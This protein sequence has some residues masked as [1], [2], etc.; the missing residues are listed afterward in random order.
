MGQLLCA[1]CKHGRHAC[2]L[3]LQEA[4]LLNWTMSLCSGLMQVSCDLHPHHA[5][6]QLKY[7]T[8]PALAAAGCCIHG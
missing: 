8:L 3:P 4:T 1:G 6:D 5:P 7:C 2:C